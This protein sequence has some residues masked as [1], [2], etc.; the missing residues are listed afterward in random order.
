[1]FADNE[2]ISGRQCLRLL[3][4][5]FLGIGTL[6]L[7]GYLATMTGE[8]GVLAIGVGAA[9]SLLYLKLLQKFVLRKEQVFLPGKKNLLI[10]SVDS[11]LL[12]LYGCYYLFLEDLRSIFSGR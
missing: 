1:M 3:F 4:F 11:V 6:V 2:M 10:R 9:L 7:P 8:D 12:I 5:D